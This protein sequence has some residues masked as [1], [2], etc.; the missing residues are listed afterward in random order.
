MLVILGPSKS[1]ASSGFR[2]PRWRTPAPSV[3]SPGRARGPAQESLVDE[4]AAH[5]GKRSQWRSLANPWLNPSRLIEHH[6]SWSGAVALLIEERGGV[7]GGRMRLAGRH[8]HPGPAI[9]Q[10]FLLLRAPSRA[11]RKSRHR[12]RTGD[13]AVTSRKA[14]NELTVGRPTAPPAPRR[15]Q[16]PAEIQLTRGEV[17]ARVPREASV[18]SE[19]PGLPT[20][21]QSGGRAW[22]GNFGSVGPH[23]TS[24]GRHHCGPYV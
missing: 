21:E 6:G 17:R 11:E 20:C 2:D 24:L 12:G 10:R 19:S 8:A 3:R 7:V 9:A 23:T 18:W 13:Q 1:P 5:S 16:V 15:R 22:M 4:H 14:P